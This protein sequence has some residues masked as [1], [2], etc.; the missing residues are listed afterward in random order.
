MIE[1]LSFFSLI[2]TKY[3][4][5]DPCNPELLGVVGNIFNPDKSLHV[6]VLSKYHADEVRY[7][8]QANSQIAKRI[9]KE[10]DWRKNKLKVGDDVDVLKKTRV[11][12]SMVSGWVRGRVIFKG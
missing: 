10:Q 4:I 9:E 11:R 6:D 1:I 3:L 12:N 5:R 2:I 7:F 8:E